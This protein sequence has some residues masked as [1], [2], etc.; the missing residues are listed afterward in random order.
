MHLHQYSPGVERTCGRQ[1]RRR[2]PKPSEERL[3]A[4]KATANISAQLA[5]RAAARLEQLCRAGDRDETRQV[6]AD[7]EAHLGKLGKFH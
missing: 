5:Y 1:W 4:S 3:P 6:W 7:F 2:I